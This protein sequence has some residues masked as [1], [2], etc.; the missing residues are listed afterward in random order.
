[1]VYPKSVCHGIRAE[2]ARAD[3]RFD[4]TMVRRIR[5]SVESGPPVLRAHSSDPHADRSVDP[6]F[7]FGG[8]RLGPLVGGKR[9]L[10]ED[11]A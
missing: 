8:E 7:L 1:M 2:P 10:G 3:D 4:K 11:R 6:L 5:F 9:G